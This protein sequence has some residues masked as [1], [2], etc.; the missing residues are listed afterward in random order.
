MEP[1]LDGKSTVDCES[2]IGSDTTRPT[3]VYDGDRVETQTSPRIVSGLRL[4]VRSELTER[5]KTFY[6]TGSFSVAVSCFQEAKLMGTVR[7]SDLDPLGND[8]TDERLMLWLSLAQVRA[9][10][11]SQKSKSQKSKLYLGSGRLDVARLRSSAA[12]IHDCSN[13]CILAQIHIYLRDLSQAEAVCDAALDRLEELRNTVLDPTPLQSSYL[14]Y[15]YQ[16]AIIVMVKILYSGGLTERIKAWRTRISIETL[17]KET[18]PFMLPKTEPIQSYKSRNK[19]YH[20]I[21]PQKNLHQAALDGCFFRALYILSTFEKDSLRMTIQPPS[22]HRANSPAQERQKTRSKSSTLPST[23]NTGTSNA[24]VPRAAGR[25]S[26]TRE[27]SPWK[28]QRAREE[29]ESPPSTDCDDSDTNSIV[30]VDEAED[31]STHSDQT[32][33]YIVQAMK[34][35]CHATVSL[36]IEHWDDITSYDSLGAA[37]SEIV[38]Y[39]AGKDDRANKAKGLYLAIDFNLPR[40]V[41]HLLAIG[42]GKDHIRHTAVYGEVTCYDSSWDCY[43]CPLGYAAS[44]GNSSMCRLL[45]KSGA[46]VNGPGG[47]VEP[48]L[49][50]AIRC[51]KGRSLVRLLIEAGADLNVK[52]KDVRPLGLAVFHTGPLSREKMVEVLLNNG[53]DPKK[54]SLIGLVWKTPLQQTVGNV[55]MAGVEKLLKR[56]RNRGRNESQ[57]PLLSTAWDKLRRSDL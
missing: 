46:L 16:Y 34:S 51:P 20:D 12:T 17:R 22:I 41:E 11:Y 7:S 57:I 53:A 36:L 25:N 28:R 5:G 45:L 35:G 40:A 48:P 3:T 6:S 44:L 10:K 29:P 15:Q 32:L 54:P 27:K 1:S 39:V 50:C 14:E 19:G 33:H 23:R 42:A 9:R 18:A 24:Q 4:S 43:S 47:K 37:R 30:V 26:T 8:I 38:Y 49:H 31:A 13:A 52:F 2:T 55:Q 56:R 21:T